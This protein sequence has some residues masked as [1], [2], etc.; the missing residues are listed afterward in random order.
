MNTKSIT[1]WVT[2]HE[3]PVAGV[4]ALVALIV[5]AR[6][7]RAVRATSRGQFIS[8]LI[9]VAALIATTVQ[10]SGMW[11]F[12]GTT[13]GLPVGFRIFMF[14]FMEIALLACGLR[15][16][17]NVEAGGDAGIDG[18]L[19]W[20]LALASG[21]MSSTEAGTLQEA[22]MRVLTSVVVA[23]LWTRDLMAAKQAA[24]KTA[25]GA[26]RSGPVRWRITPERVFVFLRLADA[27]DTDVSTVEAGRQVAKFL[28]LTDRERDGWRFPLT[29]KARAYRGRMRLIEHSL[30][31][32]DATEVLS[33][34]SA[35]AF[36][37]ARSR[38]HM[39]PG[40]ASGRASGAQ[41]AAAADA[42]VD[43][44]VDD[45]AAGAIEA[46][47][48]ARVDSAGPIAAEVDSEV[49]AEVDERNP[50]TAKALILAGWFTGE[51]VASVV[52]KSGR[53]RTYV[54]RQYKALDEQHG[55]RARF[56]DTGELPL[57]DAVNGT[58]QH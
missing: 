7:I 15:A 18:V 22:L 55:P 10:A 40:G 48:V 12:F 51:A 41:Q 2:A 21:L 50:E 35:D 9:N 16:R 33:D 19:V 44:E 5:A 34:L 43:S 28:R 6:L 4:A 17:A 49:D 26:R 54:Y 24:R 8:T 11:K 39:T 57:V 53:S 31:N 46:R 45:S 14:A 47:Q 36:A 52:R 27:V 1:A 25:G 13:M 37:E 58:A 30:R 56:D 32:G 38:L 3:L 42:E 23:L 29:P 20:V